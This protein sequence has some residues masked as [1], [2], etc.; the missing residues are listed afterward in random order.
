MASLPQSARSNA[1][2]LTAERDER[3][4]PPVLLAQPERLLDGELV[5][6]AYLVVHPLA[7]D[8]APARRDLDLRLGVRDLL[9]EDEDV[10]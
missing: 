6:G 1:S 4:L 2:P 10:H 5:V 9:D 7:D 8:V 3:D